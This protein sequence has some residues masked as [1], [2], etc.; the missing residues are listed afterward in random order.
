MARFFPPLIL[1]RPANR[2]A[3]RAVLLGDFSGKFVVTSYWEA[4]LR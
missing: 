1:R 2:V 3:T 4:T